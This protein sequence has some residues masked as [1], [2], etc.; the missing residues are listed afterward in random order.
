[1]NTIQSVAERRNYHINSNKQKTL[2]SITPPTS[3][4]RSI[5]VHITL[6]GSIDQS[7]IDRLQPAAA[8]A[9]DE[10]EIICSSPSTNLSNAD[11]L[12]EGRHYLVSITGKTWIPKITMTTPIDRPAEQLVGR[13]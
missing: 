11:T 13:R 8:A 3:T 12:L 4:D 7:L 10:G 6:D 2:S 9:E 5:A 1:V